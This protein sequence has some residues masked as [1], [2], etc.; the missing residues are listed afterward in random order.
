MARQPLEQ[1]VFGVA[2]AALQRQQFVSVIDVLV[3]LGW[4]APLHVDQWRQGRIDSLEQIVNC[5]PA[6]IGAALR[7]CSVGPKA[8]G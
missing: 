8:R 6:K 1:R 5:N 7:R 4:L 2:E 3:G